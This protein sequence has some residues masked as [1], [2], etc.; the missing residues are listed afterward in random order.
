MPLL[1]LIDDDPLLRK[2][3][4][5]ALT[6]VGHEVLEAADGAAGLDLAK[7]NRPELIV[8]DVNMPGMDGFEFVTTL[9]RQEGIS[10]IPVIMLTAMADRAN[11]RTG[12]T[13][14]ADDYL[15]KPFTFTELT[16]AVSALLSKRAALH[17]GLVSSM[18]TSFI[19]ALDEQREMLAAQYERRYIHELSAR[20]DRVNEANS[21]LRYEH[22][23]VLKADLMTALASQ[24]TTASDPGGLTRRAFQAARD[25]LHLFN[26]QHLLPSG[27]DLLAI[28]ADEPNYVGA[29]ANARAAK[30]AF[31]IEKAVMTVIHG[32]ALFDPAT[33]TR[34]GV[35]VSMQQGPI[36]LV[37]LSD[38]L[39]GDPDSTLATGPTVASVV[40]IGD[41]AR[42][43]G[44]PIACS[45]EMAESLSGLVTLGRNTHID[46][47]DRSLPPLYVTEL[48]SL[49]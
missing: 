16:E 31:A 1:L 3:A 4:A 47:P 32:G 46:L 36:A 44:W 27:N 29:G 40:A 42:V 37:H 14:G 17:E 23:I 25:V 15:G 19:S 26:A 33:D 13:S 48:L 6:A 41:F 38:P 7:T 21:E 24:I 2:V 34:V 43:A 28:F 20:W 49:S 39:H 12:M 18:N 8:C 45:Q 11:M 22:A 10:D 30:A 35:V 9:R 5:H